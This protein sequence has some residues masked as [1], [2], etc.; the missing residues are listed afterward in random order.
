VITAD[1]SSARSPYLS[2]PD[3]PYRYRGQPGWTPEGVGPVRVKREANDG[4]RRRQKARQARFAEFCR[5]R[6]A[7][8]RI[9]EAAAVLGLSPRTGKAYETERRRAARRAADS[10][11]KR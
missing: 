11:G 4:A 1:R 9:D 5:L 7:G 3:K 10:E 6:G 2:L 8:M